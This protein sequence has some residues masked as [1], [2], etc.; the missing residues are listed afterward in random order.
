MVN[1]RIFGGK[2]VAGGSLSL[3]DDFPGRGQA[4]EASD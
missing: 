4:N 1:C 3:G 2:D